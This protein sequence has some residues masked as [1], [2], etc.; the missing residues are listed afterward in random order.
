MGISYRILASACL[1]VLTSGCAT[2]GTNIEGDFTCRAPK[3]D[4][5]PSEVID[6]RATRDLSATGPVQDS[7]RPPVSVASGD[8]GR[9]SERTLRIVFPAHID[10]T[11]TLHDDAVAWAVVENPRWAAELRRKAGEDTAAPLMRQLRRQLKAAQAKS[12]LL[13]ETTTLP[14]AE[15]PDAETFDL[16]QPFQ[17]SS[18]LE[19]IPSA[20]PLVLPSTAREAV[21]GA[22]A[23]AV[24][25]F[26]MAQPPHDRT[27]RPSA[28]KAPLI[29]P[30]IEAIEAAK[31]A[32]KAQKEP[33]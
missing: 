23:P 26:D 10:E 19:D 22:S 27:P 15:Q 33:K 17:P 16:G 24:E 2:F 14:P 7:L 13:K 5:A 32:A 25:G 1:A 11:G 28:D 6:A 9:T 21:A 18:S 31:N 12:D 4:C 8:Q 29:F 20:S 30:T 3:G